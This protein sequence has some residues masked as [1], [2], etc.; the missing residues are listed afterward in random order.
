MDTA[1]ELEH[2]S[3]SYRVGWRK[4]KRTAVADLSLRVPAGTV[5]GLLGP[6]GAGKTTTLKMAI[7]LLRP[8][9]GSVRIF[10]RDVG[11]LGVRRRVGF[12]PES[13]YFYAH[14]TAEKALE[15]YARLFGMKKTER[16]KAA[17]RLLDLV[18]LADAAKLP[19]GKFSKGMLQRFGIAQALVNNPDLLIVDEP[20]SGLDPLGQVEIRRILA[21]LNAE[22]KS[23]LLSS[24]H[25][26]EI[27]NMCQEVAVINKGKA[28]ARGKIEKL[29]D[30]GGVYSVSASGLPKN[31]RPVDAPAEIERSDGLAK[32]K[33]DKNNLNGLIANIQTSG[34]SIEE[35][36]KVTKTLEELF[37]DLVGKDP[38]DGDEG[39]GR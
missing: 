6:N 1:L 8:D 34:G 3:K 18:G 37:L 11:D 4:T 22:G 23:I 2:V 38:G 39:N 20:A 29:L 7:G 27:E 17:E 28:V 33:V 12:L 25:L 32:L 5:F 10:G 15:F 14:L 35:V 30:A 16:R 36:R 31:W 21:A 13:P 9:S 24:H 26:S 19:L